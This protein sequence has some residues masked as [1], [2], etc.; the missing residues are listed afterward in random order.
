MGRPF[1]P[2]ILTWM[3][4]DTPSKV[5]ESESPAGRM[6]SGSLVPGSI[7]TLLEF[8]RFVPEELAAYTRLKAQP[9][10]VD[11]PQSWWEQLRG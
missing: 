10:V 1:A 3:A 8:T 5:Y 9:A 6:S 7:A 11:T 2:D 4:E